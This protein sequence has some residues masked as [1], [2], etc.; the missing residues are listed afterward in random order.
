MTDNACPTDAVPPSNARTQVMQAL[1]T[2]R[3]LFPLEQR[4]THATPAQRQAYG[5]ILA[6]WVEGRIPA[7]GLGATPGVQE[8]AQQDA[9]VVSAE[10]IGCY[11]F[12]A[13]DSAIQVAFGGAS[14]HAMCAI[15]ALAI[16]RLVAA[17]TRITSACQV[18]AAPLVCVVEAN[19]AL[20]HDQE[21]APRVIWQTGARGGQDCSQTLC[22]HIRFICAHCAAPPEAGLYTLAQAAVIGNAFF[23]FQRTLLAGARAGQPSK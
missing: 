12:S 15:D 22:R 1:A 3:G 7:A 10:G 23:G 20:A 4:I 5:L 17:E 14:V 6:T 11:P 18:C 2:L 16:A 9:L 8:L 19:G 21:P 13:R